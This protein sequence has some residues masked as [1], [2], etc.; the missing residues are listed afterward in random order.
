MIQTL[1]K[2]QIVPTTDPVQVQSALW[3]THFIVNW[4]IYNS[5]TPQI[6]RAQPRGGFSSKIKSPRS[7]GSVSRSSPTK[8]TS[9]KNGLCQLSPSLINKKATTKTT[10]EIGEIPSDSDLDDPEFEILRK[11]P[12]WK[13][14]KLSVYERRQRWRQKQKRVKHLRSERCQRTESHEIEDEKEE[15]PL[16][17]VVQQP[18]DMHSDSSDSEDTKSADIGS[19]IKSEIKRDIKSDIPPRI[20]G[21]DYENHNDH[22]S[23]HN[24][25]N[26]IDS[27]HNDA[28]HNDDN[29][30]HNQLQLENV[31]ISKDIS[32]SPQP[33]GAIVPT[34]DTPIVN[35]PS[36]GARRT[37]ETYSDLDFSS[38]TDGFDDIIKGPSPPPKRVMSSNLKAMCGN[39]IN[40]MLSSPRSFYFSDYFPFTKWGIT[41]YHDYFPADYLH[42]NIVKQK[43]EKDE[44][45]TPGLF[46]SDVREIFK[47][48][49]L[50]HW[51][52]AKQYRIKAKATL[53][54]D[55]FEEKYADILVCF[56]L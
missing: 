5:T 56:V 11:L 25:S 13:K 16:I 17:Q 43:L 6:Q 26:H 52:G 45:E 39:L 10:K 36:L 30:S 46:A 29:H 44:Y 12:T 40:E 53:L 24:D 1:T 2:L 32:P 55:E 4:L 9:E 48:A 23:N 21:I 33:N 15:E 51:E 50:Y 42:L 3:S 28:N 14:L 31:Q 37:R 47:A 8:P 34:V 18:N 7:S 49:T 41:D 54:A 35:T 19:D 22:D 20:T 27:N 38:D